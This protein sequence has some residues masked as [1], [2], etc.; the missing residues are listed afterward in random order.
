MNIRINENLIYI[1]ENEPVSLG[2]HLFDKIFLADDDFALQLQKAVFYLLDM[3]NTN[4]N[5]LTDVERYEK[6]LA[7]NSNPFSLSQ[8]AFS[9]K[10][11]FIGEHLE[12]CFEIRDNNE[13]ILLELISLIQQHQKVRICQQCKKYF[14]V[15]GN[16]DTK[17]CSRTYYAKGKPISCMRNG[18]NEAYKNRLK[19]TP[20]LQEYRRIYKRIHADAQKQWKISGKPFD[21]KT[22]V[23]LELSML[24][25]KYM[26]IYNES[27]DDNEQEAIY[28]EFLTEASKV[29]FDYFQQASLDLPKIQ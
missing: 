10:F 5:T 16:F 3:D 14:I 29:V 8:L 15:K 6:Y 27:T 22:G 19:T 11:S 12:T 13:L 18:I 7:D 20:I 9:V 1:D 4:T 21:T 17:Y 24:R 23:F 28:Q 2:E 25:D 26:K